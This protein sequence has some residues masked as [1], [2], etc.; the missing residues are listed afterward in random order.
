MT[1]EGSYHRADDVVLLPKPA[2]QTP[3]MIGSNGRRM[4]GIALAHVQAWNTWW[5]DY[6][7][8]PEG[9]AGLIAEIGI[10][11]TVTRSACMLV[12]LDGQPVERGTE[13]WP[14]SRPVR[15]AHRGTG[16][17]R[18]RRGDRRRQ[19]HHG[20]LDPRRSAHCSRR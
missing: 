11:D 9:F 4:L 15:R 20:A 18:R 19:P 2:R 17:G 5:D 6:H 13:G 8:T 1:L 12:Q 7:N 14:R 16:R 10:P 3:I